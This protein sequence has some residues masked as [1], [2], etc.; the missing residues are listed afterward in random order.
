MSI[1]ILNQE[2]LADASTSNEKY[3]ASGGKHFSEPSSNKVSTIPSGGGWSLAGGLVLA[4][5]LVY[6]LLAL[7]HSWS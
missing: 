6:L 7:R 2:G 5:G 4:A 3:T 1:A